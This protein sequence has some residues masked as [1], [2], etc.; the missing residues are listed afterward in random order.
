M[1]SDQIRA[2]LS[3]L[4]REPLSHP[5]AC[6]AE[7]PDSP[8]A[9]TVS[10][11]S[12]LAAAPGWPQWDQATEAITAE[13][14]QWQLR[15]VRYL[16]VGT[17][18]ENPA[19]RHLTIRLSWSL[20]GSDLPQQLERVQ[21]AWAQ[22]VLSQ[23]SG[24][25]ENRKIH[26]EIAALGR[27]FPRD[28][29]F[30]DLETCGLGGAMVFLVGLLHHTDEGVVLEQLLARNYAEERA[31]LTTLWQIAADKRILITFNGK[32]F[33]W[34]L[35]H[36]RSTLHR[37]GK[38]VFEL[39]VAP[40][41]AELLQP[42]DARP[43]LPHFDVLHHARRRWRTRLPNCRLQTLERYLCHRVRQDDVPGHEIPQ[44]YHDYVRTG[45]TRLMESILHHNALD[46]VTMTQ[47]AMRMLYESS[48]PAV[49]EQSLTPLATFPTEPGT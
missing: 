20:F 23:Q 7:G 15:T 19:G 45:N 42:H 18:V 49:V 4:N 40:Q 41:R 13:P 6:A 12:N 30:L 35:V 31:I 2:R 24:D 8:A 37:L 21:Q 26:P 38:R 46:L 14:S 44:A 43:E 34:P 16:E 1:L 27:S 32:S 39:S 47:V 22:Q 28:A 11:S 33:D 25:S 3:L 10:R 29:L 5:T 48:L 36:D 17:Q 9:G